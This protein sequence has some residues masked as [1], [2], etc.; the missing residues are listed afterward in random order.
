L[1]G[2]LKYIRTTPLV[3]Y[4]EV[5]IL[6]RLL[7]SRDKRGSCNPHSSGHFPPACLLYKKRR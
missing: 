7:M 1:E 4:N 6:C 3:R 5:C 2:Y